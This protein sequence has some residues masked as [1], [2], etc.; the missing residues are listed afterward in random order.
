MDDRRKY[1][2]VNVTIF[3]KLK[4][5]S[6]L[7]IKESETID[8]S[9]GGICIKSKVKYSIGNI[10]I[11]QLF[12]GNKLVDIE[13]KVIWINNSKEDNYDIGIEYKEAKKEDLEEI[14]KY[15]EDN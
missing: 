8:I 3:I 12:L 11:L 9:E 15:I 13:G 10:V 1:P 4:N 7:D 2:R 5:E 14:K 6:D